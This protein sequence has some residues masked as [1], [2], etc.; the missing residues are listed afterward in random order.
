M[1]T[2]KKIKTNS[3]TKTLIE[4]QKKKNSFFF[5]FLKSKLTYGGKG[6]QP[7]EPLLA[8]GEEIE[9]K[10]GLELFLGGANQLLLLRV[11][12]IPAIPLSAIAAVHRR[13]L[14]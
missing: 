8:F 5:L 2:K 7:A 4:Q 3:N 9:A 13:A 11:P 6:E 1:P 14:G 10:L 12:A